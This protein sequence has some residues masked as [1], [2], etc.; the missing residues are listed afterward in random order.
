[1]YYLL[2]FSLFLWGVCYKE[3]VNMGEYGMGLLR[4]CGPENMLDSVI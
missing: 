3:C 4:V 1:M 2:G